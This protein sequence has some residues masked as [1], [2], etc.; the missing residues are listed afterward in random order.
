MT[1]QFGQTQV[2]LPETVYHG[3]TIVDAVPNKMTK[4]LRNLRVPSLDSFQKSPEEAALLDFDQYGERAVLSVSGK[5]RQELDL[6]KA[7]LSGLEQL[8][9]KLQPKAVQIETDQPWVLQELEEYRQ[10]RNAFVLR[11]K[12]IRSERGKASSDSDKGQDTH[13]G[14]TLKAIPKPKHRNKSGANLH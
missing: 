3:A 10:S 4:L 8:G 11:K 6:V 2:S 12:P 1:I 14:G 13:A 5:E 7:L 9:L